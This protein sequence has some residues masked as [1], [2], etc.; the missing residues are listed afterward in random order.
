MTHFQAPIRP[1]R[2]DEV[3]ILNDLIAHSTRILQAPYYTDRQLEG[4]IG[5]VF[6]ADSQLI[7][8]GTYYVVENEG[9]VVACGGWSGR[10]TLFGSDHATHREDGEWMDPQ[11]EAARI[12]AFFVHPAWARMGI[13]GQLLAWCE[14][15]AFEAGFRRFSLGA[16]LAG[17]P[18]YA[19]HGYHETNNIRVPLPN[20]EKL[21]VVLMEKN[22]IH[23]TLTP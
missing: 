19:R 6:G 12:R 1:A 3:H 14:L 7:L 21:P 15:K 23:K 9:L 5:T 8:D 10:K 4:A 17:V 22:L 20:G 2:M 11:T 16:T 18:L 13:G